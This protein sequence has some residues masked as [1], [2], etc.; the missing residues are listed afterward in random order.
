MRTLL[1]ILL[2]LFTSIIFSQTK[3]SSILLEELNKK[4]NEYLNVNIFFNNIKDIEELGKRLDNNNASFEERVKQ[5]I[6]LQQYNSDF[7]QKLFLR[8]LDSLG[9]DI[10][11]VIKT[12]KAYWVVNMINANIK[13][14]YIIAISNLESI[15]HIDLNSP[16]YKTEKFEKLD[17]ADAKSAGS[18][19]ASL[20]TINAHKMWELG[21]SGKNVLFLSIDTGVFPDHPAINENFAGNYWPIDQ[22]WHGVRNQFPTDIDG[23]GTHTTGTTLG[24]DRA[25]NDTIGVAFN[26][27]WIATDPVASNNHEL[28]TPEELLSVFQWA[29]NPDGE[30]N[31]IEDIPRVINNSWGFERE[32]A[33]IYGGCN[34]AEADV[35][36][37]IE[38]AGICSPFSA[39]NEGPGSS[40]IGFPAFMAFNEVNPL[41]VGALNNNFSIADFSSRGP[42]I[43]VEEESSLKIKPEVSAPGVN[44]RSCSSNSQYAYASGTSMACPHVSGALL[45]LIE[46][47]PNLSAFELKK[48]LYETAID[49]GV[50]GEDNTFGKGVIDV[51]GAYLYLCQ[52]HTPTPPVSNNYDLAIEL[53]NPSAITSCTDN[54]NSISIKIKNQGINTIDNFILKIFVDE[55]VIKD[56]NFERSLISGEEFV[57]TVT[58]YNFSQTKNVIHAKVSPVYNIIE[59]DRF[60]NSFIKDFYLINGSTYP[61]ISDFDN[62]NDIDSDLEW[63]VINPDHSNR[64]QILPWGENNEHKAIGVIFKDYSNDNQYDY[65]HI[66]KI[67]LP[68]SDDIFLNFTYAYKNWSSY[69]RN[70]SLTVL[71]STDCGITFPHIVF[72]KG[73]RTLGTVPES[74]SYTFFKPITNNE[75]DTISIPLREFKG[76][77]VVIRLVTKNNKGTAIYIDEIKINNE[78]LVG[79]DTNKEYM[80]NANSLIIYPNPAYETINIELPYHIKSDILEIYNSNGQ[81]IEEINIIKQVQTISTKN[82]LPGTYLFILKNSKLSTNII[83]N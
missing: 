14:D 35:L 17:I 83:I 52:N 73:G 66:N 8:N 41:S 75:F 15:K 2:L 23:H 36:I 65:L 54:N 26:A 29:M 1:S 50:D 25:T 39:G 4:D 71:I 68:N 47:F 21:Y 28:L 44:I 69:T 70:D 12:Q 53:I 38:T 67:T 16:R 60:N 19:E 59:F 51:Y 43:C 81:K 11:Q 45:L 27:K 3:I 82:I 63:T 7:S 74:S 22:C 34:I 6:Q 49:L 13:P 10:N 18:A 77:D 58:D 20:R 57:Y 24:L 72:K 79:I 56:S 9:F 78:N 31:T 55:E 33:E 40:T 76:Q 48:A 5:V 64:W 61:L 80:Y 46:A 30:F 42:S 32:I 37:T 62:I